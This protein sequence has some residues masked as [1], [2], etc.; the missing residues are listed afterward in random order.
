[1][2]VKNIELD[3]DFSN[4]SLLDPRPYLVT[5]V[6]LNTE[7]ILEKGRRR[8]TIMCVGFLNSLHIDVSKKSDNLTQPIRSIIAGVAQP[9]ELRHVPC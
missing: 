1:M 7:F 2:H 6:S 4:L 5:I 9:E 3:F 8:K